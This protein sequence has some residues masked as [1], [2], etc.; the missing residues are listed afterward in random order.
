MYIKQRFNNIWSYLIQYKVHDK[1]KNLHKAMGYMMNMS[2]DIQIVNN[3][4]QR[5]KE[6]LDMWKVSYICS[7]LCWTDLKTTD[8]SFHLGLDEGSVGYCSD[9]GKVYNS[10]GESVKQLLSYGK[11]ENHEV[12]IGCGFYPTTLKMFYT[13]NGELVYS[14]H[15]EFENVY[16]AISVTSFQPFELNFGDKK[17]CFD[18]YSRWAGKIKDVESEVNDSQND[19]FET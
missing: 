14:Q 18:I 11:I 2:S 4:I 1:S 19:T 7:S 12:I 17:F 10:S 8:N 3:T 16:G 5:V 15:V 6:N 13:I 9:D